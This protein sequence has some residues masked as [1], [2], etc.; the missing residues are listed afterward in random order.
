MRLKDKEIELIKKVIVS[1]FKDA[2]V[3]IFGS[4]IDENKR[5]GDIDL[6]I[7]PKNQEELFLK[8]IKTQAKLEELLHKPIDIKVAKYK[9]RAIEKEALKNRIKL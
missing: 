7:I 2:E 5:R 6:Y 1:I 8:K 3:Y 4:R 9:S